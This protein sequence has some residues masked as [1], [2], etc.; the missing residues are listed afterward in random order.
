MLAKM[1]IWIQCKSKLHEL[2]WKVLVTVT[3]GQENNL[4]LL[5]ATRRIEET[6]VSYCLRYLTNS[7]TCRKLHFYV[8][9]KI[10]RKQRT[11]NFT[12][13]KLIKWIPL[14]WLID[15][16]GHILVA[17]ISASLRGHLSLQTSFLPKV[18]A[19]HLFEDFE[20]LFTFLAREVYRLN[21]SFPRAWRQR[22]FPGHL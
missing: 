9:D 12:S 2:I 10:D 17:E 4:L 3:A 18:N 11:I 1:N 8:F 7:A 5:P 19:S 21:S 6:T 22:F 14:N 20:N 16:S 13:L 15:L